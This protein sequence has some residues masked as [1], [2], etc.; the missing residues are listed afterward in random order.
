M[1]KGKEFLTNIII[2]G[3]VSPT[4]AKAI[5]KANEQSKVLKK[6]G[7]IGKTVAKATLATGAAAAA[8]IVAISKSAVE[9]YAEYEQLVGGVDTLFKESSKAVQQYAD[10][11][12]KTAGLS[13]N[14]YMSTVTSFS[15][16]MISSLGGD[17]AKAA[18]Y[19]NR[20]I[21]DMSDNANKMGTDMETIQQAYQSMARGNYGML[22]S[23]KIGYG[24]TKKEMERLLKDASKISGI[25]YNI[26]SFA[27]IT[28]AIHVVQTEMG[29]TGTTAKEASTTIQGSI[30]AMKGAWTNLLTGLGNENADFDALLTNFLESVGTVAQN[31]LPRISVIIGKIPD[32]VRG[33][34]PLIPPLIAE[35]LPVAVDGVSSIV[36]GVGAILPELVG[37]VVNAIGQIITGSFS[38]MPVPLQ[39]VAGAIAA[40]TAGIAA[41]N[42]VVAIKNVADKIQEQ[43]IKKLI[44]AQIAQNA[45]FLASPIFWVVAGI[46]ALIAVIVLCV[47][48][49]DKIKEVAVAAW[50]GIK[51]AFAAAG[52][53]FYNTVILPIVG[54][55]TGLWD[56]I[57]GIFNVAKD[58]IKNNI[59]SIVLFIINPF[60]GVFSYLYTNFEGFRNFINNTLDKIK[61]IFVNIGTKI[62]TGVSSAF[63]T[64]I[65]TV[66]G[67]AEKIINGFFNNINAAIGFINKIPGVNIPLIATLNI[68]RLATGGS[69]D[70]RHPQLAVVGD[71][72][73]TM[74]PHGNT[75]RNRALLAEA[76]RGVGGGIGGNISITFAPVIYGGSGADVRQAINDSEAEFERKM[77]LYF[78]RKGRVSFA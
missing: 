7:D 53:W 6:I 37:T 71:A 62:A 5:N 13:A 57:T 63:K 50:E 46:V 45:A 59:K 43:G 67:F 1:A 2:G 66:I 65:N 23:L 25:K 31:L 72:P 52:S 18:E 55:F 64:V 75:P 33:L 11:A 9:S 41:Y 22:D 49:W 12:Y 42:A 4:L 51:S 61:T 20:A 77:D 34:L 32:M 39:I 74:V 29:I 48:H 47:K 60:A 36:A 10:N 26:S 19:A 38:K 69:F 35:L 28:E 54:F 56:K 14:E 44:A 40:V 21:T 24:G 27:D 16:S 17:T 73:E 68:P 70:G 78:A 3:K 30:S 8:G 58:W 15:A 76:A